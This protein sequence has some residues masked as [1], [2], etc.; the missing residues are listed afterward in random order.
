MAALPSAFDARPRSGAPIKKSNSMGKIIINPGFQC[1]DRHTWAI[2]RQQIVGKCDDHHCLTCNKAPNSEDQEP[3]AVIL[4]AHSPVLNAMAAFRVA[5]NLGLPVVYEVRSFCEDA[6][7][8]HGTARA[9]GP[10]YHATRY[11]ETRALERADAISEGLRRDIVGGGI[12]AGKVTLVP[13]A[14]NTGEF[15]QPLRWSDALR[16]RWRR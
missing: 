7:L 16:L 14:V 4:H 3:L 8:E 9:K 11:L 2:S 13:N 6:A 1:D 12:P 10:R 15:L 5:P